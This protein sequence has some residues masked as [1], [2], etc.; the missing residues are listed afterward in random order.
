MAK[1]VRDE[2]GIYQRVPERA[3][4]VRARRRAARF[5]IRLQKIY[6]TDRYIMWRATGE[7]GP[8]P[9]R[10]VGAGEFGQPLAEVENYLD[11]LD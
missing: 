8:F 2:D 1:Y 6:G 5:G 4:D 9:E 10:M 7:G 3:W 11:R